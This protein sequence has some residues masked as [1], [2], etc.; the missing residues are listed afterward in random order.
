MLLVAVVLP[1]QE[2]VTPWPGAKTST[3]E[4]KFENEARASEMVLAPT[5]IAEGA[6]AG[7]VLAAL[8]LSLPAATV[9]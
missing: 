1:I 4:P 5:V 9:T 7:E 3:T 8:T 6:R 2:L